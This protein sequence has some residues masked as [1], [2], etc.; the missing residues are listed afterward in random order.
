MSEL[1]LKLTA[2]ATVRATINAQ[3]QHVVSVYDVMDLACPNKGDSWTKVTWKGLIAENSEFKDELEFTMEYLK[4]K[5]LTLNN[6][7]KRRFRKTPV[8]TTSWRQ[9]CI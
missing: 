5:G 3:G 9:M 2:D 6:N 1:E 8:M 4:L 7:K